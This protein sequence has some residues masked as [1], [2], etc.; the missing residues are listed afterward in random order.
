MFTYFSHSVITYA[1]NLCHCISSWLNFMTLNPSPIYSYIILCVLLS[2]VVVVKCGADD[3]SAP[4]KMF[5]ELEKT[6]TLP[7][8][9]KTANVTP[10]FTQ[11]TKDGS[12]VSKRN[13]TSQPFPTIGHY[14]I[15]SNGSL[16][17]AGLM[18]IDEGLY[19]CY[20]TGRNASIVHTHDVIQLQ[21]FSK[22]PFLL[23]V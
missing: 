10:A 15:L 11:W 1:R 21:T 3:G 18:T 14:I 9:D 23:Q 20:C 12:I 5:G 13:H 19:E 2:P 17:I 8:H 4:L 16:D 7:C 6:V 22:C